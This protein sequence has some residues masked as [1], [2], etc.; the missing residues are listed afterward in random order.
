MEIG[1]R[2]ADNTNRSVHAFGAIAPGQI[3]QA[4]MR[5]GLP[6]VDRRASCTSFYDVLLGI[7]A[8]PRREQRTSNPRVS[9]HAGRTVR[10]VGH[11]S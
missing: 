9:A 11:E 8:R 6:T 7:Q 1:T 10:R 3:A 4:C 5:A 2:I